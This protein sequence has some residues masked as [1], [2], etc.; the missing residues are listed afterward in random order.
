M[1]RQDHDQKKLLLQNY[2]YKTLLTELIARKR[3]QNSVFFGKQG[4]SNYIRT[5][6]FSTYID[7]Y[8]TKKD[9]LTC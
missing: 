1:E 9:D 3:T 6:C 4:A 5:F 7:F 2:A 8:E